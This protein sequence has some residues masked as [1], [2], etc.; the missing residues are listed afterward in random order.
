MTSKETSSYKQIIKA[1][2][3]FGGVQIIKII[4]TIIR[5]KFIAVLLGPLGMGIAGLLTSTTSFISSLTN[6]GLETS[7]IKDISIAHSSED[8]F[9]ISRVVT[10]FR[11]LIWFT[12]LLGM[13][14]T[15]ILAPVLSQITFGNKDYTI[16]FILL[17]VILLINQIS[18][19][20]SVLLRGTRQIRDLANANLLGSVFSLFTTIPFYYLYGIEGIVPAIIIAALSNLFLT[21]FYAKRINIKKISLRFNQAFK[22][23]K[24]MI[25][26]GFMISLSGLITLSAS[27]IVRIF[28]SN[29]GGIEQVGLYAA[30]FAIVNTYVGM[31]FSAMSTDFYPRLA[32]VSNDNKKC[33]TI[34]NQQAE[35]AILILGPI[36]T[37]FIIFI[38]YLIILLYSNRFISIDDMINYAI[39]GTLFKAAS[40]SIAVIFLAKGASKL[41]FWNELLA[42]IYLLGFNLAGYYFGGLTGMG[43]S[44]ALSYLIYLI[45]MSFISKKKYEFGFYKGFCMVFI[46]HFLL[47]AVALIVIKS[48]QAPYSYIYGSIIILISIIYSLYELD[49]RVELKSIIR[50][51]LKV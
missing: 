42:N 14:S 35:I 48:I 16:A 27:Y 12:G 38:H 2:S 3:I 44:F 19:G 46:F 24:E 6:F 34:I 43:I 51:R 1:T 21:W 18:S 45:Q 7:A 20:Q 31:V 49:K 22:E 50:K 32:A 10:V 17:S 41:Y 9:R 8:I 28:I 13:I 26:L 11:K 39:I 29:I 30:G 33:R 37:A 36:I 47:S 15:I 5:S 4:V 23:G 40:W 25:K